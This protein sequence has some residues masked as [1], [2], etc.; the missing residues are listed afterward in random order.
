MS[1]L[2]LYKI[3]INLTIFSYFRISREDQQ[4]KRG[5]E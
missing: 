5:L 3:C 4:D 2:N 1:N